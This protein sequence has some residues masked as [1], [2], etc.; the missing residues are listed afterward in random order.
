MTNQI[1]TLSNIGMISCFIGMLTDSRSF[2]SFPRHEYFRRLICNLF[3]NDIERGHL[4][5][6]YFMIGKIISDISYDNA[7]NYFAAIQSLEMIET[8]YPFGKYAE[9]AQAELIF[10]Y[11][12]NG[13]YESAISAA[14]RFISLHTRHPNTDYAFYM[15]G[16]AKF[17]K[18]KELLST[19][20]LLG[21]L[22]HKRDLTKAKDS[23]KDLTEF[24]TRYPESN[25]LEDA[26]SRMLFL[27]NLISKQEI[28]VAEFY[29]ERKAY[30]AAVS[31]ADYILSNMPNCLLYTSP[32]PRDRQ[33]SRMPSS[34]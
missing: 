12:E 1:N 14:E 33:K 11:Y 4:P 10:A 19:L 25:Y 28:E 8:R 18:D 20:P 6:D 13:L 27:R 2:L 9:Q 34:A 15:K 22:T 24:I 7:K 32:S 29:I 5:R 16:L 31:R 17:S 3:G 30:I 23:F 26:K 21:D